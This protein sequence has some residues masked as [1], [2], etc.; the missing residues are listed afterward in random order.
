VYENLINCR[1]RGEVFAKAPADA[2]NAISFLAMGNPAVHWQGMSTADHR[3][4]VIR[5]CGKTIALT[6]IANMN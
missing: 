3:I 1:R 6:A 5:P 2:A 4:N